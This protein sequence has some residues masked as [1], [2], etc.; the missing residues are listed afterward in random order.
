MLVL[1]D[2]SGDHERAA[3]YHHEGREIFAKA[4]DLGGQG[5]TLSRLSWTHFLKGEFDLARRYGQEGLEKF[6]A[7]NH[8]WGMSVSNGRIG[9]AEV[10]LGEFPEAAAHFL[11]ALDIAEAAGLVEQQLYGITGLG[12]ALAAMGRDR[13]AAVLLSGAVAA[14][15]NPYVEFAKPLLEEI[16]DRGLSLS[17][18]PDRAPSLGELLQE[19]RA[20]AST[21]INDH[22][23]TNAG[24]SPAS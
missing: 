22:A 12:R 17:S 8:R 4:G 5:Y 21:L 3:Q 1:A 20:Y 14:E 16:V 2:E 11:E 9:L 24:T 6:E 18:L 23:P 19:A 7:I 15:G 13:Q 10:E